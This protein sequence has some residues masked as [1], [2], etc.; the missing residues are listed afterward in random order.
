MSALLEGLLASGA[1]WGLLCAA[2]SLA[3][4]VLWRRSVDLSDKVYKLAT[5]LVARDVEVR[6]ALEGAKRE[7]EELRRSFT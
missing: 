2:L 1:P 5:D 3:V 6:H 7:L 4:A